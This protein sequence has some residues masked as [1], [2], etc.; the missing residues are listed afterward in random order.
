M[1]EELKLNEP[2]NFILVPDDKKV[3]K[4][5]IEIEKQ[6]G[7]LYRVKPKERISHYDWCT[8]NI[9]HEWIYSLGHEVY[10]FRDSTD[11]SLFKLIHS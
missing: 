11:A 9:K 10:Y 3:R 4:F 1:T 5:I 7:T 6:W 8:K 2:L